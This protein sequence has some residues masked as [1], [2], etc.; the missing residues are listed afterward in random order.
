MTRDRQELVSRRLEAIRPSATLAISALAARLRAEGQDV[1]SFGAGEPDLETPEPVRTAA[2]RAIEEGR[3]RYTAAAGLADLRSA[4]ARKLAERGLD[5]T[6]DQIACSSGAKSALFQT[7]FVLLDPGD[8]VLFPSPHWN[9]YVDFVVA[10]G[11]RPVPVPTRHEDGFQIDPDRV[12]AALTDRTRVLLLNSP[13]NPT[14]TVYTRETLQGLARIVRENDLVVVSDDIYE[15]LLY[16]EEPFCNVLD[17][18][19][20]LKDR[21]V[22]ISG[23]SKAYSMTGWRLGYVAGPLSV[24]EAVGRLQSQ[25]AGSPNAISQIGAISGLQAPLDPARVEEFDRRRRLMLREL[26]EIPGIV[27]PEPKG[28]FYTFPIVSAFFGYSLGNRQVNT[29]EDLVT[30]LL[31]EEQVATVP[32]SVFGA[33]NHIRLTYACSEGSIRE[34]VRRIGRLLGRLRQG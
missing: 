15:S 31:E 8:E 20:D 24:V 4:L 23:F 6:P 25:V 32:G 19:P 1:I 7:M 26:Q 30:L 9:S 21:T 11:G 17:V 18:A 27:C 3:G 14:G 34:G 2:I 29:D 13:N 16:T 5:Y 28:A 10:A 12:Q 33:P 22:L